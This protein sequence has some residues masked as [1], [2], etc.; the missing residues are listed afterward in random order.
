MNKLIRNIY[1]DNE[2]NENRT[3]EEI[4]VVQQGVN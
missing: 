1:K 2:L 4:S 3:T